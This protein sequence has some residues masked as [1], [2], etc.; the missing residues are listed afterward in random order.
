MSIFYLTNENARPIRAGKT[1]TNTA[2]AQGASARCGLLDLPQRIKDKPN[3]AQLVSQRKGKAAIK[4]ATEHAPVKP[5]A[6]HLIECVPSTNAYSLA[7][8]ICNAHRKTLHILLA[9]LRGAPAANTGHRLVNHDIANCLR[10]I[11]RKSATS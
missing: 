8:V 6:H 3:P 1:A 5:A 7:H 4:L 9:L 11:D 10:V 2:Q